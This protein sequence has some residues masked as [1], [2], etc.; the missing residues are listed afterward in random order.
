MDWFTDPGTRR[1]SDRAAYR[2]GN[3]VAL[4]L[5]CALIAAPVA[6]WLVAVLR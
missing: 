2:A 3:F 6:W 1:G 5:A 4:L